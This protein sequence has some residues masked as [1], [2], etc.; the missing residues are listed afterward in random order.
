M[1]ASTFRVSVT[2]A[3]L[4]A[5]LP[6]ISHAQH[7]PE[8]PG[9]PFSTDYNFQ[10]FEPFDMDLGNKPIRNETGYFLRVD[11]LY[12]APTSERTVIGIDGAT[13]ETVGSGFFNQ[14][15]DIRDAPP[16]AE[17]GYGDRY[18]FG[19]TDKRGVTFEVSVLDGPESDSIATFADSPNVLFDDLIN[20]TATAPFA[21]T[22]APA[23]VDVESRIEL[24]GIELIKMITLDNRHHM[25]RE[26]NVNVQIGY[27]IRHLRMRDFFAV[28]ALDAIGGSVFDVDVDADNQI[29]G[30]EVVVKVDKFRGR[31]RFGFVGK[32]MAG[33]NI[34]D[35][36][37]IGNISDGGTNVPQ[38]PTFL[39]EGDVN[40]SPVA[41]FRA[42]MEYYLTHSVALRLGYTGLF[43]GEVSRSSQ[44]VGYTAP[45]YTLNRL[46]E[47]HVYYNGLT[48]GITASY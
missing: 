36:G 23:T 11:K 12:W 33:A 14:I 34:Q 31:W 26:Q 40:F 37:L 32:F 9:E 2:A 24:D 47:Q 27:G 43:I 21:V 1:S 5:I 46:D 13:E 18:E 4:I 38:T 28:N 42:D 20:S 29:L 6:S 25:R 17:F 44:L 15:S 10:L 35:V 45:F 39:G 7:A 41:E 19:Y 3:A 8:L 48:A 22:F 30:P 16:Q